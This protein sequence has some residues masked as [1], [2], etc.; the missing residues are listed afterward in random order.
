MGDES[1]VFVSAEPSS[2]LGRGHVGVGS[3]VSICYCA[4]RKQ[5]H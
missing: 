1:S 2:V 5:T 3:D 4:Q